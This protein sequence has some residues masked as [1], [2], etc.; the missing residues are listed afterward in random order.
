MT[1]ENTADDYVTMPYATSDHYEEIAVVAP[2][3]IVTSSSPR[4]SAM[5]GYS[6]LSHAEPEASNVYDRM[7]DINV[8]MEQYNANEDQDHHINAVS[9]ERCYLELQP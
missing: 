5:A 1:F 8:S 4:F 9:G 7:R 2:R 6:V 3:T